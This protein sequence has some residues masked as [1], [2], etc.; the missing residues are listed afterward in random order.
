MS[1]LEYTRRVGGVF[2]TVA[3]YL[4]RNCVHNCPQ[5]NIADGS[6]PPLPANKW[7][8]VFDIFKDHY[9]TEFFLILGTEPLLLRDD[10]LVVLK[11]MT[12]RGLFY[13]FYSTSPPALFDKYKEALLDVGLNNYSC[14]ID[15]IADLMPVSDIVKRKAD[16]GIRGMQWMGERGVQT[17]ALTTLTNENLSYVPQIMK[18][19][20]DNIPKCISCV[21]P[22]EWAH[23][24]TFDFFPPKDKMMDLV[25]PDDRKAEVE[26]MAEEVR[27]LCTVPGY[28]IQNTFRNLDMYPFQYNRL[29]YRCNGIIGLAVDCDGTLRRCGYNR[30]TEIAK[31]K[32]WDIPGRDKEIYDIWYEDALG[33]RGCFWSWT[34]SLEENFLSLIYGSSYYKNRWIG[35]GGGIGSE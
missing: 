9:G 6:R 24:P 5:C 7:A 12:K 21:N 11:E 14:G 25:I 13:G 15:G 20:Q 17:L 18:W 30:G 35:G 32:V 34:Q 4:N 31:Y 23:D 27:K 1:E 22:V 3:I 19:C 16:W 33:C 8:E 29:T 26:K 28:Y 10:L 2:R